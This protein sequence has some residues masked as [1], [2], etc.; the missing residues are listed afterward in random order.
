MAKNIFSDPS[1]KK[2]ILFNC[3]LVLLLVGVSWIYYAFLQNEHSNDQLSVIPKPIQTL[4]TEPKF[5]IEIGKHILDIQPIG[6]ITLWGIVTSLT[7][8][9]RDGLSS[10]D[11]CVVWGDNVEIYQRGKFK[12]WQDNGQCHMKLTGQDAKTFKI[13]EFSNNHIL[14]INDVLRDKFQTIG[15]GDEILITGKLVNIKKTDQDKWLKSSIIRQDVGNGACEIILQD[16]INILKKHHSK[17]SNI[18]YILAFIFVVLLYQIF[19]AVRRK[20]E[21]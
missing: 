5:Q 18:I 8:E 7:H 12:C 3:Y 20:R 14:L 4:K 17:Y 16:S 2:N 19:R 6:Y 11:V 15:E 10:I 1:R 9:R 21:Y 13:E